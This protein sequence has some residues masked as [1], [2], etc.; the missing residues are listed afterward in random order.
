MNADPAVALDGAL[1]VKCVAAAALTVI[2][3]EV[4]AY[5]VEIS[6]ALMV[7][8]PAVFNVAENVPDPVRAASVG[9]TACGSLL[10][11]WIVPV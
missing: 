1:T 2:A 7:C 3:F 9:S 11:K 4:P 5:P 10:L 6:T 8:V